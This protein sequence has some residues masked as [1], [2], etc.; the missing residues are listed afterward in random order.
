MG[1]MDPGRGQGVADVVDGGFD[2]VVVDP[3]V[4][5]H[6][7]EATVQVNGDVGDPGDGADLLV[8]EVTQCWQVMPL[9]T[10]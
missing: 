2:A 9:T 1:V 6:D 3:G 7:Q 4:T 8:T 10:N 5:D